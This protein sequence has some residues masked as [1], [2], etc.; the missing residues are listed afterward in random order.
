[1]NHKFYT[2][3]EGHK[4]LQLRVGDN[5][6]VL[7]GKCAQNLGYGPQDVVPGIWEQGTVA[8]DNCHAL[9]GVF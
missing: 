8:C 3:Q 9:S 4:S 7:C 5:V 1:M 2:P 6:I